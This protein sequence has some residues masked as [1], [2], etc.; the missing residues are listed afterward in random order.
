M[1]AFVKYKTFNDKALATELCRVLSEN[2]IPFEWEGSEGFFDMS[3]A[4]NDILNLYHVKLLTTDFEK[5]DALLEKIM[6]E[7]IER[8]TDDYYLYSFSVEELKDILKAPLEW[9]EFDRYW[10]KRLL[11][12]K[13]IEAPAEKLSEAKVKQSDELRKA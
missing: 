7:N 12:E 13:G 9:N 1:S 11:A 6:V 3:F 8:P 5:A 10:A 4:N 2:N